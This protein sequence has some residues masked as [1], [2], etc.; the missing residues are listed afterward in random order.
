MTK[1]QAIKILRCN[2]NLGYGI[3]IENESTQLIKEAIDMAIKSLE[4]QPSEDCENNDG[5]CCRLLFE[6]S[7]NKDCMSRQIVKEGMIKYG[8]CASDMTVTKFIEDELPPV[9]PKVSTSDDCVSRQAALDAI[10]EID[11]NINMD[12]YTNEVREIINEL[13]SVRPT[14]K[15]GKWIYHFERDDY[16]DYENEY[17]ECPFCHDLGGDKYYHYCPVCGNKVKG[18]EN[19]SN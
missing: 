8:F 15:V 10:T 19:D 9:T 11:D 6:K 1:T 18:V 2:T 12:I 16:N 14:L 7:F 13:S 4:Q 5:E 17:Y 3:V